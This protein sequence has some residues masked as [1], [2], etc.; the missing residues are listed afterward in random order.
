MTFENQATPPTIEE[1]EAMSRRNFLTRGASTL[2][3]AATMSGLSVDRLHAQ[4]SLEP[5]AELDELA[6]EIH[7]WSNEAEEIGEI[8][9][10]IVSAWSTK[11]EGADGR[12]IAPDQ[13]N[14]FQSAVEVM[15][16]H[17]QKSDSFQSE[18]QGFVEQL[19]PRYRC[20][21]LGA[22]SC[23]QFHDAEAFFNHQ[24]HLLTLRS[25]LIRQDLDELGAGS[26][27]D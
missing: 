22:D 5:L 13:R 3:A 11:R 16:E 10:R 1:Q 26:H 20:E 14:L 19:P 12:V 17:L 15:S 24:H 7:K 2:F 9:N 6:A 8:V 18:V 4:E 21:E 25:N 23:V 27:S